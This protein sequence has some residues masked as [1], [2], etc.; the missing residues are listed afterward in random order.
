MKLSRCCFAAIAAD[1]AALEA[2]FNAQPGVV[3]KALEAVIREH[4]SRNIFLLSPWICA[5]LHNFCSNVMDLGGE[6]AARV[7]G[8]AAAA[9]AAA[10]G[11]GGYARSSDN[12]GCSESE[13]SDGDESDSSYSSDSSSNS[14]DC[15]SSGG[16]NSD[17]LSSNELYQEDEEQQQQQ[18]VQQVQQLEQAIFSLRATVLKF[19]ENKRSLLRFLTGPGSSEE[20]A[21]LYALS[22]ASSSMVVASKR[23]QLAI[24]DMDAARSAL[25]ES[26]AERR[27]RMWLAL[28]ARSLISFGR[29]LADS[30]AAMFALHALAAAGT[31]Q[32][33]AMLR[34]VSSAVWDLGFFLQALE[35]P[36]SYADATAVKQLLQAMT[37]ACQEKVDRAVELCSHVQ[38][39]SSSDSAGSA[40]GGAAPLMRLLLEFGTALGRQLRELGGAL[41]AEFPLTS[42]CGNPNCSNFLHSSE[43]RLVGSGS[44]SGSGT[45]SAGCRC[46]ACG[47]VAWCS[48]KCREAHKKAHRQVCK[49]LAP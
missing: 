15:S 17:S 21:A 31:G 7:T 2:A 24:D 9:A 13:E 43:Q 48:K 40:A 26:A 22:H 44:S 46:G 38:Q 45:A 49:R 11:D 42:C 29:Q 4:C 18:Q 47:K 3:S 1:P 20:R 34:T 10:G 5:S 6:A 28:M 23:I 33:G 37:Q 27:L 8:R 30:P 41:W 19:A 35:L 32:P 36:G 25:D 16:E 14:S 39:N 12:G